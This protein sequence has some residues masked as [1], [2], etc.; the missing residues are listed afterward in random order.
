MHLLM[1]LEFR[2]DFE[3]HSYKSFETRTMSLVNYLAF[4]RNVFC[5][6]KLR[7]VESPRGEFVL[8]SAMDKSFSHNLS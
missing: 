2:S 6:A 7:L 1:L 5:R 3:E 4:V 8:V